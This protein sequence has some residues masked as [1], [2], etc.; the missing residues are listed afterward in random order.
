MAWREGEAD[1]QQQQDQQHGEQEAE[2]SQVKS[3]QLLQV[4]APPEPN[5]GTQRFEARSFGNYDD[6][7]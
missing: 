2:T 1:Y 6:D 7:S 3:Q 4:P 5:C